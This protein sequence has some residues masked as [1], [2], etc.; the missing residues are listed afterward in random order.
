MNIGA[1]SL[2]FL[3]ELRMSSADLPRRTRCAH[4]RTGARR[5]LYGFCAPPLER[6]RSMRA[7]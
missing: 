2:D 4:A 6:C 1:R 3:A 5:R 7:E